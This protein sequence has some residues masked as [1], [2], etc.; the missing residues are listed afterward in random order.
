MKN[1]FL[2]LGMARS[3]TSAVARGL[4]ALGIEF[5]DKLAPADSLWNPKGFWEDTDIVYKVNRSVM[6]AIDYTW[7]TVD[8]SAAFAEPN[9]NLM[10][11]K[12]YAVNLLQ[13]RLATTHYYGFKDPRIAKILPFWQNVFKSL[14]VQDHYVIVLRNP[15]SS[16]YSYQRVTGCDIETGL[17]L[18]LIM[19]LVPAIQDSQGKNCIMVSFDAMMQDPYLQLA[20]IKDFFNLPD[21]A[22]ANEIEVYARQFL[23]KK[24]Q[25]YEYTRHDLLNHPAVKVTPLCIDMYDLFCQLASDEIT[26]ESDTFQSTWQILM[27]KYEQQFSSIYGYMETISKRNKLFERTL[28]S[29]HRSIPW[30]LTYVLRLVED[31]VRTYRK[32]YAE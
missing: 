1:V 31:T 23:D 12:K 21:L 7:K 8:W 30:K 3:G 17:L 9:G 14:P 19:H 27:N 20:R 32:K 28:R 2:V 4:S 22:D 6:F 5:G 16:A 25:H 29:I 13:Q 26:F 24:L 18:W 10:R 15:L 11:L